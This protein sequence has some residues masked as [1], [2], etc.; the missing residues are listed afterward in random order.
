MGELVKINFGKNHF[1][2]STVQARDV[3]N[4]LGVRKY[5]ND[6]FNYH[7]KNM[8]LVEEKDFYTKLCKNTGMRGRPSKD[9]TISVDTAKHLCMASNTKMSHT[10]R[11]HFI[12]VEKQYYAEK[13]QEMALWDNPAYVIPRAL[14]MAEQQIEELRDIALSKL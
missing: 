4:V 7:V 13:T 11:N 10:I 1:S 14:Q 8:G 12:E 2:E 5:F 6:W 9:Y 3:H